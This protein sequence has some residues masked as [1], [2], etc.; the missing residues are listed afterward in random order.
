MQLQA[1]GLADLERGV[2][3]DPNSPASRAARGPVLMT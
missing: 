2:M 1:A 3:L